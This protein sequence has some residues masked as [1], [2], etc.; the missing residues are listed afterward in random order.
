[1]GTLLMLNTHILLENPD[2]GGISMYDESYHRQFNLNNV[3]GY[4]WH[5]LGN[6]M[7]GPPSGQYGP[8]PG[9][10][11]PGSPSPYPSPFFPGGGFGGPGPGPGGGSFPSGPQTGGGT[12]QPPSGPPPSFTPQQPAVQTFAVDPGAIRRCLHRHTYV[13]TNQG[14]FWFFP[15]FVGRRSI[16]GFRWIGFTWIYFGIDLDHIQ[17]FQCF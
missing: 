8:G 5:Q 1:M 11:F 6:Q 2:K 7:F 15:T 3:G 10:G 9:P 16:A 12:N 4:M 13:W 17:S 14:N